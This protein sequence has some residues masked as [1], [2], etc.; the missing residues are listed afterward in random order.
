MKAEAI[1]KIGMFIL[2]ALALGCGAGYRIPKVVEPAVKMRIGVDAAMPAGTLDHSWEVMTGSGNASLYI[3]EGW[4]EKILAHLKDAHE[5]LG[6]EMVRFHGIFGD[7]VGVYQGPGQYNFSGVDRIYDGILKTGVKPFIELSF[8]PEA[9]ASKNSHGFPLGYRPNISPP[10]DYEEWGKM[11]GAFTKHLVERYGLAEVKNWYFEVWNEPNLG[12]PAFWA[13]NIADYFRLYDVTARAVKAVSPELKVGGPASSQSAWV[14]E[15]LQHCRQA[16]VPVDFVSTHGYY[17]ETLVLLRPQ[18]KKAGVDADRDLTGGFF[19]DEFSLVN[20]IAAKSYP[21]PLPLFVTEWNSSVA[22]SYDMNLWPNDH[23]LP[24]DA[25]FMCKAVKE[26]NGLTAGFSHWTHSDVFE[27]WGLPGEHW[28]VK[29]AA[30]HGGFGLITGDGIHKPSYHAFAFLHRMG[31]NLVQT[32]AAAHGKDL[33]A[34]ATLDS[35]QLSVI[36]WYYLDTVSKRETGGPEAAVTLEVK[37]LPANLIGKNLYGF[38]ID[39]SHGDTFSEWVKMGKPG[40]LSADQV[41][42]LRKM[43]DETLRVPE[44]DRK[45]EGANLTLEFSLPPAGVVFLTTERP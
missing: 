37:N 31:K 3:R 8:M 38:R 41:S 21:Q 42:R 15:F 44:L 36:A 20:R 4:D 35:D 23:D 32:E 9:L 45:L 34:M 13:G 7:R 1:G 14:F 25:A 2:V 22:Y 11:V 19:H 39:R 40:K 43:S 5:N 33:D 26:T 18:A 29:K 12:P 10:K 30:Y 27:E 28:P 6:I 24:N 17:N 16:Q